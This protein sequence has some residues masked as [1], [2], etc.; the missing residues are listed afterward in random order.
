MVGLVIASAFVDGVASTTCGGVII[1]TCPPLARAAVLAAAAA[2][3]FVEEGRGGGISILS[4]S[5]NSN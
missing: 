2:D 3:V 1:F 5:L 4:Y